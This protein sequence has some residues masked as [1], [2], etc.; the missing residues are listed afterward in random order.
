MIEVPIIVL[1]VVWVY[2]DGTAYTSPN[3]I[4]RSVWFISVVVMGLAIGF[5]IYYREMHSL[6]KAIKDIDEF[7]KGK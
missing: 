5:Y 3:H 1:W 4:D 7:A 2:F 6:N